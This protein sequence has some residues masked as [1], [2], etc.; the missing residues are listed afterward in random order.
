M[1][2]HEENDLLCRVEG[3]APMG[4][5]MRRHWMPACLIEEVAEPDCA[6]LKIRLLGEDLVVFRDSDGKLGIIDEYCPH[7][8]VSLVFGRNE[9]C[10]LR[11]LYHGWK[12]DVD[13]NVVEMTSEPPESGFAEK[14]KVKAYPAR[15]WGG[16]VW[17]YM[18][19]AGTTPEFEPPAFAPTE[20]TRVSIVKIHVGCN[21]A[22]ILEGQI[23]SAHSSSLH[24][25]DMKPAKV[26]SA[27]AVETHWLRP[28][29][30]K[31]P[32]LQVERTSFGFHYAAIRRPIV[33]ANTHDYVRVTVYVAPFTA[34]IPP[35]NEY[36][37]A[38]L[39]APAD[40][41][42]TVFH[43]IAWRED[44]GG[45][46]QK[47]WRKFN[48]A[49]PGIDLDRSFNNL[50]TRANNYGQDRNAMRLGDFTG[51]RGIPNQDIAMWE[52]M[53]PIADRT[54]EKLGASDLA[55]V[56]F[57]RLMVDAARQMRD[58]GIAIGRT[59]PHIAHT[60][61]RSFEGVVPKS[62]DWRSFTVAGEQQNEDK[63]A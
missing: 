3:D 20:G 5:I 61:I 27:K 43:F 24:S 54:R 59:D 38:T 2:T 9:E 16:F 14:V 29:T 13:G 30:D 8:R 1:M 28:S 31:A 58:Q 25:S 17:T 10:G 47:A 21:W 35:N 39:L 52:T 50:R 42:N 62:T 41:H 57:R 46:D 32:R 51:I 49:Q 44:G 56:E 45:I 37:V 34:L 23:D 36:K 55:V 48:V 18:G 53:G 19:P 7:R 33:N 60:Q 6:P 4:Q 11:C 15:E 26:D 63:V 22:Q 12:M 40:D